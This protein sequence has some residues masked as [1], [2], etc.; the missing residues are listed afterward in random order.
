M[1]YIL[2]YFGESE[3][4][5]LNTEALLYIT[6]SHRTEPGIEKQLEP[7]RWQLFLE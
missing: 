6:I 2:T 7:S 5:C 3:Q 4:F 1:K